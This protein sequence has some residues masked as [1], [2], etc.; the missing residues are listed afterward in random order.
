M[1]RGMIVLMLLFLVPLYVFAQGTIT[2]AVLDAE[3]NSPLIGANVILAGTFY[4]ASTDSIGRFS[5]PNVPSGTYTMRASFIGY[6]T[7]W[8]TVAVTANETI[9]VNFSL[10]LT[11]LPGQTVVVTATRARE[12]QTP[13]TFSNLQG[14]DIDE[15]YT[16]QDIPLLLSE[17]PSTTYYSENGNGIGYN[18]LNIRGFDQRRLAVMI[19]GVPQNDPEDH[20]VYWLDFPDLASNTENIQVQ[21][22]AGNA[23]YGPPAIG[24]SV[25]IITTNF[26]HLR[27]IS[28]YAGA[29]SYN[30][31]K[32]SIAASSGLIGNR[33]AIY[34]RLSK[35]K[36][37]GYR[38]KSWVDFDSY[39]LGAVRYDDNM[40]TQFNFYGGPI[41]DHLAY[42]GIAKADIG[43]R[44][45]RKAN[46]IAR[47]EEIENFSQPHYELLH[48]W[49]LSDRLTLN[50]TLF[51]VTGAGFF[52]YDASWAD[53]SYFRLTLDNGFH[54]KANP[55][56]ALI[57][58]FV[59]NKQYGWLPRVTYSHGSGELTAGAEI[60]IHRSFHWGRIQWAQN[61]PE[62]VTPDYH[63]YEYRG[64]KDIISIYTH[65]LYRLQPDLT[66]MLDLQYAFNRY[67][68][69]DE[70]Y[71]NTDFTVPYHFLN[72]RI[73]MNYNITDEWN[74]YVNLARTSHEPRLK[75][76]YSAGEERD[77]AKPQ[78]EVNPDGSYD[79]SKPLVKP[80]TLNDIEL[81]FGY[82]KKD[83]R[84]TANFFWMDFENEI[85]KKGQVDRFGQPITGNA[86]RTRHQGVEL[87]G[88]Y[89]F[90][91]G[92][93]LLAN[94][95]LS[96]N[97]FVKHTTYLKAKNLATGRKEVIPIE[98]DGNR[99]SGFPDVL[100]NAR[101]TY[102][103]GGFTASASLQYVS[104]QFTDNFENMRQVTVNG[105]SY[106]V[107]D[108]DNKVDP[109]T[110]VNLWFS[111][112][113]GSAIG[114]IGLNGLELKLQVNN[115]FD[116]LYATHGESGE[117]F[118]AAERNFFLSVN[119]DI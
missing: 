106:Q 7:Q 19:N 65:E 43:D 45:K 83:V 109:Y 91:D 13:V 1:T 88:V 110:V 73:G 2:G 116:N 51:I 18:Y 36:S 119:L 30:T 22:G 84:F 12:R 81:G 21:R 52:D 3:R 94:A 99:I 64:A 68:L 57:R 32:Y 20:N 38:D 35:I 10:T 111:Y 115:L 40:T 50:N 16:V 58:A 59:D 79:F 95:T 55:E 70:K 72:P 66:L 105:N 76:L 108:Y 100:A 89:R 15:R 114:V 48:E 75:N 42:Y 26:T 39:F 82:T 25:N 107:F 11:A 47:D 77:G 117:F 53:T 87:S 101:L 28:L 8:Q 9:T 23:F 74:V 78:F 24:G 44:D 54:A 4:G 5:I 67:R 49:R 103:N 90:L 34:G 96:Q 14:Q 61:L 93:E 92:F 56:E 29:G 85:V 6:I 17:L 112:K 33:Y 86:E 71:V 69:Y 118:P 31:Q 41:A 60:R 62:G 98:L 113:F 102:R 104:D 80:E 37:D 27:R 63:Y 97:R 46:P